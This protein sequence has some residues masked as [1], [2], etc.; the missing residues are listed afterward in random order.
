MV[1]DTPAKLILWQRLTTD[2]DSKEQVAPR[3]FW[4]LYGSSKWY[5]SSND[6][7]NDYG[8]ILNDTKTILVSARQTW[9]GL[10]N[11]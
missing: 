4:N 5:S 3:L 9:A 10:I 1:V 11:R 8:N 2:S 6:Y 7:G